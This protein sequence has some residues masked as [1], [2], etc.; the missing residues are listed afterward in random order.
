MSGLAKIND[1]LITTE[2]FLQYLKFNDQFEEIM[3]KLLGDRITVHIARQ[4]NIS[5]SD[6]ELQERIDQMRRVQGLHRAKDTLAFI[7][8]MG[9]TLEQ[10][11]DYIRDELLKAKML[12]VVCSDEAI[13]E[14]FKLNSPQFDTVELHHILVDSEGKARELIAMLEDEPDQFET[15]AME[16]SLSQDTAKSGGS[17]GSV[18]R[19]VLV[20]EVESKVFNASP[21]DII[22]P[23]ESA[24]Q[25]LYEI[26]RLDSKQKAE[27]NTKTSE[28]IK[29]I[30]RREWIQARLSEHRVELM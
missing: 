8:S 5:V 14:Y 18:M 21:G 10:F 27:L 16:L 7:E 1:E 19:G 3:D 22:G 30:L 11:G 13:S 6:E 29:T 12:D 23:Y 9:F 17:L 26:F 4:Q 2:Y 28:A 25:L 24:D 15:L 20:E